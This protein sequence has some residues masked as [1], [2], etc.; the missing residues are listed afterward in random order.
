MPVTV[1]FL[2]PA[3]LRD[4]LR[5]MAAVSVLH[6]ECDHTFRVVG[7]TAVARWGDFAGNSGHFLFHP[8]GSVILGFDHESPMSPHANTGRNDFRAWPG[9]Y[10]SLPESLMAAIRANPFEPEFD[11]REVTFCLWNQ[12][13]TKCWQK[14]HIEYPERDYGDADGEGYILG[15]LCNY[16]RD[17]VGEFRE[18]YKWVLDTGA[19]AELLSGDEITRECVRLLGPDRDSDAV[20][21]ELAAM[22]FRIV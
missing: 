7:S 12:T 4:V 19:V 2:T 11:L 20:V 17:F 21:T 1:E 9:V 3:D 5:G 14:G 8:T 22:G 6:G 18:T 10:E 15:W 13:V 16:F